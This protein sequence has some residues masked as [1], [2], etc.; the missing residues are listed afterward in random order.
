MQRNVQNTGV[1]LVAQALHVSSAKDKNHVY[2]DMSYYRIVNNI[3][4][5]DYTKFWVVMLKCQCVDSNTGKR[6]N[7]NRFTLVNFNKKGM[8]GC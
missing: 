7:K 8:L 2:T 1:T 6:V 4:E 3:Q 5:V